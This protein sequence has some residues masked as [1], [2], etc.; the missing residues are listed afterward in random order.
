MEWT[1][2]PLVLAV[3]IIMAVLPASAAKKVFAATH[4]S[5]AAENAR[6]ESAGIPRYEDESEM[7]R[8]VEAGVLVPVP[9][10]VCPK[11]PENR[12]YVRTDVAGFMLELDARV[13]LATGHF[14]VVD[15]AVRPRTVQERLRRINRNAA[16]AR[17]AIAS[18]HERGTTF[19]IAKKVWTHNGYARMTRREYRWLILSL[20]YYRSR[21][22]IL[23]I[24]E[25][26]CFHIFVGRNYADNNY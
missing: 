12:R 10:T 8:D 1:L 25:R 3:I 6:A 21:G 24:E 11:L 5:V 26:A 14:L 23:V 19:D 18:S 20:L 7:Q 13:Y 15:S 17:G 16:P 22:D 2:R 4:G 9:I